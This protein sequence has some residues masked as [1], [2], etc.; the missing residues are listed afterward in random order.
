MSELVSVCQDCV[1]PNLQPLSRA[2]LSLEFPIV[3]DESAEFGCEVELLHQVLCWGIVVELFLELD[4]L[5]RSALGTCPAFTVDATVPSSCNSFAAVR[6]VIQVLGGGLPH[7]RV[8]G[9][10]GLC[11][12][13]TIE[14]VKHSRSSS[15]TAGPAHKCM[16]AIQCWFR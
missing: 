8:F 4:Q 2:Y 13:V 14:H 5:R 9:A 10:V 16:Y 3:V 1:L 7:D 11:G 15:D 12:C 6:G